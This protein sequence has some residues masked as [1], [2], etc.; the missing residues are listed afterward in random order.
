[1]LKIIMGNKGIKNSKNDII[2]YPEIKVG[3]DK[4]EEYL[5]KKAESNKTYTVYSL[6]NIVYLIG[7]LLYLQ[8][9]NVEVYIINKGKKVKVIF[10]DLGY[11]INNTVNIE[12]YFKEYKI[13]NKVNDIRMKNL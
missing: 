1:M 6:N 10:D 12:S 4:I 11:V 2:M 3:L 9:K 5:R 7:V 8:E 13:M